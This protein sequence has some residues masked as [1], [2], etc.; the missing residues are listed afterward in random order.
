M[1]GTSMATPFVTG[2]SA[3]LMQWGIIEGNDPYLYGERVRAY[4]H[5]GARRMEGFLEYPNNQVGYGR[6]C[7]RES[8]PDVLI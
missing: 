7:V 4:L 8:L 6:L 5:R 3:L 2:A 1:S